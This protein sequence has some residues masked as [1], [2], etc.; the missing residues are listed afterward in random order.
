MENKTWWK[1]PEFLY[2]MHSFE[3]KKFSL[4]EELNGI[5]LENNNGN[6]LEVDQDD[7]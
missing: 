2:K 5:N 7:K 4:K 1:G 3:N 6:S